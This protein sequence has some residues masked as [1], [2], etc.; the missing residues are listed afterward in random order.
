MKWKIEEK[1]PKE[2]I[3]KLKNY[4]P[5]IKQLLFNR[6]I[7]NKSEAERYLNPKLSDLYSPFKLK[8]I[9]KGIE[10]IKG[11]L[12]NKKKI[13]IYGD[14]DVDGVAATSILWDY[15]YRKLGIET[16][17]YIPSRFDEGYGMSEAGLDYISGEG[18][19]I[20]ITVDCGIRDIELVE[21]YSKLKN[22]DFIITDH[23]SP[24]EDDEGNL[25]VSDKAKAVIHPRHPDSR[26]PF[27]D[28]CGATVA[29]KFV[30]AIHESFKDTVKSLKDFDPIEYIDLVSL[31]TVTD[32]MPLIDENR[33]IVSFGLEKMQSTSN[34]GLRALML[35]SNID[36]EELNT[37]H[38]GFVLGPRLNAA[39]RIEHA[40]DGVRLL[41]TNRLGNAMQYAQ[42][43]SELNLKRQELTA[44]ILEIARKEIA[45]FSDNKKILVIWGDNWPEGIVGLV[46]GKLQEE[47]YRPVLVAT[48]KNGKATGSARSIPGFNVTKAI[49]NSSKLMIRYGG[50]VQAAGFTLEE[51]N[52]E[53]FREELEKFAENNI[54]DK[55]LVPELKVDME[56]SVNEINFDLIDSIK[57][58]EPFGYKNR[59]PVFLFKEVQVISKRLLG[60]E[61]NHVKLVINQSD[62]IEIL[63]FNRA[64]EF[65]KIG[66]GTKLD[67]VGTLGINSWNGRDSKQIKLI[68]FK[69][70]S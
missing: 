70:I 17:P 35:D 49:G 64:H 67:I 59:T 30:S 27:F 42:K 24:V 52:L 20:V 8:N 47:F 53:K 4:S 65:D 31:A 56:L 9:E 69:V 48:V 6:G 63:A 15:L 57:Q 29:W 39:G 10:V 19:D 2:V 14:Y 12:K 22:I 16:L 37:Y 55:D 58:L 45:K 50:H 23:H 7:H 18:G 33:V 62:P 5:M 11:A 34:V 13:F 3:E 44:K 21:K 51:K 1:A 38:Y 54:S 46:A 40:L 26:Y 28:I 61:K 66:T 60:K 41:S 25:T 32:I 68:D 43:L 36:F